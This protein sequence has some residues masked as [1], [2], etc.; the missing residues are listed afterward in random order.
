MGW[1]VRGSIFD[2]VQRN[3]ASG[4]TSRQFFELTQ[5][6]FQGYGDRPSEIQRPVREDDPLSPSSIIVKWPAQRQI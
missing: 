3:V 2:K 5:R 4:K 1:K 6:I